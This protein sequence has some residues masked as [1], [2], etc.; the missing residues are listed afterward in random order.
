MISAILLPA[1]II[2]LIITWIKWNSEE[3]K[4][5]KKELRQAQLRALKRGKVNVELKG[6]MRKLK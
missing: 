1:G 2:L 3:R 5:E 6:K 4:A